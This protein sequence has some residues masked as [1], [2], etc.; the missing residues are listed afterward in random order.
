MSY[1]QQRQILEKGVHDNSSMARVS[2][3]VYYT[4]AF[5]EDFL[6]ETI[7]IIES[8]IDYANE[9]FANSHIPVQLDLFCI[10]ELEGFV[11]TESDDGYQRLADFWFAKSK[12]R[13][14][15]LF[16]IENATDEERVLAY[17]SLLN[18]A[19]I[20]ILMTRFQV[21]PSSLCTPLCLIF[22]ESINCFA[23]R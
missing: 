21:S 14:S 15:S 7:A 9:A 12:Y 22:N 11:E 10:E 20:G 6:N 5:K 3:M 19:D 4:T 18:T 13:Q 16:A 23:G 8:Q 2:V 17:K 1:F